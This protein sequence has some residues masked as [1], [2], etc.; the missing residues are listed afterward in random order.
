MCKKLQNL[1]L[2][3]PLRNHLIHK[4]MKAML[5]LCWDPGTGIPVAPIFESYANLPGV[6]SF[7]QAQSFAQA[8]AKADA[9][10]AVIKAQAGCPAGLCSC[11]SNS[12][13]SHNP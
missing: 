12:S 7:D 2:Q 8:E 6:N 4:E 3:V 13:S 10:L 9:E 5:L 1:V 11:L